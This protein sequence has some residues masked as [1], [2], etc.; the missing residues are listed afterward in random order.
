MQLVTHSILVFESV[1]TE[2]FRT[3][4]ETLLANRVG[5]R[6]L[7]SAT[8]TGPGLEI[9]I[10]VNNF[11]EIVILYGGKFS[12]D[13]FQRRI[14]ESLNSTAQVIALNFNIPK[15]LPKVQIVLK[16]LIKNLF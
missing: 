11:Y 14:D 13:I 5:L 7:F 9:T 6:V 4:P 1:L 16:F 15:S 8:H 2:I 12:L 10:R 3:V